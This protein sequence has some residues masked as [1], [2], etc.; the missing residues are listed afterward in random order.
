MRGFLL[1][2]FAAIAVAAGPTHSGICASAYVP[3]HD[4][5]LPVPRP[6]PFFYDLYSFRGEN[7]NTTVIAA[8]AVPV[9]KLGRERHER[10][11]RYRFSDRPGRH[12]VG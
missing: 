10:A 2:L 11:M 8:F 7:G 3:T 9:S 6:L 1:L 5:T 12:P 4:L